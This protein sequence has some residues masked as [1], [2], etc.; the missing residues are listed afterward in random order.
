MVLGDDVPNY[1]V[2]EEMDTFRKCL[3]TE[4]QPTC[5]ASHHGTARLCPCVGVE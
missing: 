1:V 3:V 5:A 4:R 2:G